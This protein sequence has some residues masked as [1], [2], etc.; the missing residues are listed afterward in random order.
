MGLL[1]SLLIGLVAGLLASWI[2]PGGAKGCLWNTIL[3]LAGGLVG[4]WVFSLLDISSGGGFWGRLVV[5][6][7]GAIILIAVYNALSRKKK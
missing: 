2:M 5:S 3:G 6:V 7:V 4:G 1:S